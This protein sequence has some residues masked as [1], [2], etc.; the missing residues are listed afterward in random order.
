MVAETLVPDIAATPELT[1][2]AGWNPSVP[3]SRNLSLAD[4]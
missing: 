1:P 2:P 3:A 4:A